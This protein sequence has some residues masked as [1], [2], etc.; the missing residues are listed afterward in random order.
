MK[1]LNT[2]TDFICGSNGNR[3]EKQEIDR[4]E[5]ISPR[6]TTAEIINV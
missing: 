2:C 4:P 1:I 5:S 6:H 3:L